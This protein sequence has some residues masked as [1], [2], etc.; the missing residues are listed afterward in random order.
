M[1]VAQGPRAEEHKRHENKRSEAKGSR[2]SANWRATAATAGKG[3]G[4]GEMP[5]NGKKT[6]TEQ[7]THGNAANPTIEANASKIS[8]VCQKTNREGWSGSGGK[9]TVKDELTQT[10]R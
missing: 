7:W 10:H 3:T 6:R 4:R 5:K 8:P 1:K 9:T 2:P